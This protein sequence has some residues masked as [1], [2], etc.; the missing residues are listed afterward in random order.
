[1]KVELEDIEDKILGKGNTEDFVES[2]EKYETLVPENL[3]AQT[4]LKSF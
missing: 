4:N 1:V 3:A 2:K